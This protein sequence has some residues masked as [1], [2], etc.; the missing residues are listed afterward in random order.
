MLNGCG[1]EITQ[2]QESNFLWITMTSS[3]PKIAADTCNA[4]VN[5]I[6]GTRNFLSRWRNCS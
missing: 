1:M 2:E 3:N 6:T 4:V 5:K